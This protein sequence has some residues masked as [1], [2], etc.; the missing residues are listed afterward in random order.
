MFRPYSP[1]ELD[2]LGANYCENLLDKRLNTTSYT[3]Q[4]FDSNKS[5]AWQLQFPDDA[6]RLAEALVW[7]DEYSGIARLETVRRLVK[8]ML[9]AHIPGT[10]GYHFFRHRSGGKTYLIFDHS[11]GDGR[12]LLSTWGDEIQGLVSV[13]F[14]AQ[15]GDAW[16]EQKDFARKDT[17][18]NAG[19]PAVA[20]SPEYWNEPPF[21]FVRDFGRERRGERPEQSVKFTE[22]YWLKITM[23]RLL[24]PEG[25]YDGKAWGDGWSHFN[26]MKAAGFAPEW[27]RVRMW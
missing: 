25:G 3:H 10:Q 7:E 1:V 21:V 14:R 17:P 9:A 15:F 27:M 23:D 11:A 19:S 22:R 20:R 24:S 2:Y 13:G 5:D 6:A 26:N 18:E 16:L 8:G 12:V 4:G